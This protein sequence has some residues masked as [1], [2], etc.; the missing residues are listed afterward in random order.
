MTATVIQHTRPRRKRAGA[1]S[2]TARHFGLL[3]VAII[4]VFAASWLAPEVAQAPT[5]AATTPRTQQT[6]PNLPSTLSEPT[7]ADANAAIDLVR[8]QRARPR[9]LP[10]NPGV[11]LDA[12]ATFRADEYEILSAAELDGI[13]QARN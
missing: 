4:A 8:A 10:R 5:P 7:A 11:P 6:S 2:W 12:V 3:A 1:W 13:S 9:A